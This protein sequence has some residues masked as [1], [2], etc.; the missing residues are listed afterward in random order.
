MTMTLTRIRALVP[1]A[2]LAAL[3]AAAS[4]ACARQ[5]EHPDP[6]PL[7]GCHYFTQDQGAR[8]LQLPWGVRLTDRAL[9]GW[10]AI[11]QRHDVMQAT[12][13]TGT[14]ETDH[15]FGY[16]IRTASDSIEI[17]YPGGGGLVLELALDSGA[18]HGVARAVGDALEPLAV[19]NG[20]PT[21]PVQLVRARCPDD[22]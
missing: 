9:E 22:S 18:F 12:T 20:T 7:L 11:Q 6:R 3:V 8:D 5:P 13:L 17:G 16:W 14:A 2:S 19:S 21:R 1:S 10:P 4:G 15:P